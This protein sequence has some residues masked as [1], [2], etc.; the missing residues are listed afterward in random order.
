MS[1]LDINKKKTRRGADLH[2]STRTTPAPMRTINHLR[3]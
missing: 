1:G 3:V 2:E